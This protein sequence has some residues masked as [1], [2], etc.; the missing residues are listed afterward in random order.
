MIKQKVVI[1]IR[2]GSIS[3]EKL[4]AFA[5]LIRTISCAYHHEFKVGDKVRI[6]RMD[7]FYG[8]RPP[9]QHTRNV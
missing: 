5:R 7:I 8:F 2:S 3:Q 9:I 6:K 4:D 1:D